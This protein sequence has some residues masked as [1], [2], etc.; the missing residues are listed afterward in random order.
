M[1]LSRR[2]LAILIPALTA[3]NAASAS[4]PSKVY[5]HGQIAYE[6]D[7]KKKGRRFFRG[8]NRTGFDFE[9]HETILGENIATHAPHKHEHGEIVIVIDGTVETFMEGRKELAEAGSV[10]YFGSNQLHSARNGGTG[11]C[12]YYVVELRGN[13]S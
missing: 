12:R 6:G 2:E 9:M 1:K 4:L 8:A 13:E 5:H 7:Q 10:I 3:A 11:P